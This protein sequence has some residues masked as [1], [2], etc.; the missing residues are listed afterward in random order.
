[1]GFLLK[2]LIFATAAYGVWSMFRTWR[3][4]LGAPPV[5]RDKPP[6]QTAADPART[7][8][9][10]RRPVVEDTEACRTCGSF[11]SAGATRCGRT[12]CPLP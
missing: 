11:V 5:A 12:D 7:P 9:G 8:V 6:P 1:M 3:R 10:G 4:G 2:I